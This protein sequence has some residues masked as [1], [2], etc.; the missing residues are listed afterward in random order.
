MRIT[1]HLRVKRAEGALVRVLGIVGR[2]GYTP[3]R[4]AAEPSPDGAV[5][6]VDLTLESDRSADVLARQLS[7]CFDVEGV[8]VA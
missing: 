4:V 1:F 2:R 5:W 8:V 6:D 3:V 7:K